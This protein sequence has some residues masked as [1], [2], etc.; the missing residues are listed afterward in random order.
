[1]TIYVKGGTKLKNWD[2]GW[3]ETFR[4]KD[5][6]HKHHSQMHPEVSAPS[7]SPPVF[8]ISVLAGAFHSQ[9]QL[10][11]PYF[12]FQIVHP[13]KSRNQNILKHLSNTYIY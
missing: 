2:K 12:S 6:G 3:E 13:I 7:G 10:L 11:V 1:M 4:I 5:Y 8:E 9:V